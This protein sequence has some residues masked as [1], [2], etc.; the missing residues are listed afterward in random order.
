MSPSE[1]ICEIPLCGKGGKVVARVRVDEDDWFRYARYRWTL[2]NNGYAIST[3]GTK[4]AHGQDGRF[5]YKGERK[6]A[7]LLHRLILGMEPGDMR[8]AD[9]ISRDRLDC[10]RANLRIVT[11]A[12]N[13]QNLSV[14]GAVRYR[15]VG[16]HKPSGLYYARV[17]VNGRTHS[18]GYYRDEAE[19]ARVA[20]DAR[21]R[22]MPYSEEAMVS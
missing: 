17:T 21:A 20:A 11:Q 16:L 4:L 19:A 8:H 1:S 9:H 22:L 2:N 12:Q 3:L 5:I 10:R 7:V 15:G 13:N 14:K 6:R 18:F